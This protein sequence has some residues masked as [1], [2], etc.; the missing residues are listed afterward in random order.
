[1]RADLHLHTVYSDGALPPEEVAQMEARAGV[2]L[3]A[4]TDHDSMEGAKEKRAAAER[5]GLLSVSGWEV[6]SYS[7][8]K[9]HVLGYCCTAGEA[10]RTFLE[11][12]RRGAIVRAEDSI[13][14]ANECFSLSVTLDDAERFH[15]KKSAPLHTMHVVR[16][17]AEALGEDPESLYRRYFSEGK[18]AYS[19]LCRPTPEDAIEVIHASGGIAVLAH[20]A[21]IALP[22]EART[23]LIEGLAERGLD[24]IE[25]YHSTHT[26]AETETFL[27]FA[28]SR[29]LLVTGGSD[30]HAEGAGRV[31]GLPE[32]HADGRL[33]EA[34][35]IP[36]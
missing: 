26:A 8:Q 27:R 16:A 29:G 15:L 21:R 33:L 25:C 20:P 22:E 24:G 12:R 31:A 32:F 17:F 36:S 3:I 35:R 7:P 28:R 11:E 4:F 14:K 19:G 18:C 13:A 1:M 2:R 23:A 6:S 34:L 9:V 5:Y 30:F 10:Y